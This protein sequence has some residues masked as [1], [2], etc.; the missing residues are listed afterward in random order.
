MSRAQ[1]LFDRLVRGGEAEVLSFIAQSVTEELFLDY[2]RS[3]D[4]GA[5]TSLHNRDRA[6]LG[7]A[8]SGF[9]NSEGGVIVWGVDCR[10]DP[11]RGDVPTGPVLIHDPVRFKSWLEQATS[12]LTVPPHDGVRHHAI[13]KGFVITLI[14]SGM[15]APYQTVGDLSYHIRAGSNFAKAPHAVLAGMFGRRPQP[16]IKHRYFVPSVPTIPA[17][18]VVKTQMGIILHNYG[19]G[20]AENIF[21]NLRLT[22]HPGRLC[23][24]EFRPPEE[25]EAWWGRFALA[26]EMHLI[27]RPG[28][29]LPPEAYLMAVTFDITL[30]NP[31]EDDFAFEGICGSSGAETWRFEF[32]SIQDDV[33]R[34]FDGFV[35]TPLVPQITEIEAGVEARKFN[36]TFFKSIPNV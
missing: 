32:K 17:S 31:L 20:I 8:I 19:R 6:N 24:I 22:S 21:I 25:P 29:M 13:S 33:Y 30:Q 5:G 10:N 7:R 12:G 35:R 34:A 28:Y 2:K 16:S 9:G 3:A 26:R 23:N 36:R 1:D 18:G 27:T 14:P 11:M 4:N 15:H